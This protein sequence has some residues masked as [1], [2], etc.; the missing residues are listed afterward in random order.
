MDTHDGE[1]LTYAT[2]PD[3]PL[4]QGEEATWR[5]AA[6]PA[7]INGTRPQQD[8]PPPLDEHAERVRYQAERLRVRRDA[9]AL[10]RAEGRPPMPRLIS[11]NEALAEPDDPAVYRI[12]RL[13]PR[14]GR[15]ILSAQAK[16]GKTTLRDN[17]LRSLVDGDL[18]LGRYAVTPITDGTIAVIDAELDYDTGRRWL[19]EQRIRDQQ[20]INAVWLKDPK[21]G[22]GLAAFDLLDAERRAEWAQ[23]FRALDTRV[24][25]VDCIGP[26][27]EAAG[28]DEN[29][30][31]EVGRWLSALDTLLYDAGIP[32]AVLIHHMGH[33][34]ERSRGASRLRGW[35]DAEWR[36][37]KARDGD[38]DDPTAPRFITAAGR[39]VAEPEG[40]LAYDHNGRRLSLI[41]G[42]RAQVRAARGEEQA[43]E[44]IPA[45]VAWVRRNP[46]SSAS[47]IEDASRAL[48]ISRDLCRT[49]RKVAVRDKILCSHKAAR[50]RE[51][52]YVQDQCAEC[53][54]VRDRAV[55]H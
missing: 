33:S 50:S 48:G 14:G 44:H 53:A 36:L 46:G 34:G 55:A 37:M 40:A 41:G 27:L 39:D 19:R 17:T 16:T 31:P 5:Q 8:Q 13:W 28:L 12:D 2:L 35:P 11:L 54:A 21:R 15:I 3:M 9:E 10:L 43:A 4:W 18:F 49:A 7:R 29:S 23:Q 25:I 1:L 47:E 32:E 51:N 42:N 26:L 6:P 52:H 30:N 22:G 24:L 45:L 20:R 38:E